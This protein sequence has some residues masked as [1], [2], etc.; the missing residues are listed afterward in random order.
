MA[1][2]SR[3]GLIG[4]ALLGGF[5]LLALLGAPETTFRVVEGTI[6][7]PVRFAVLLV[8]LYL[9]RPIL[10]LP[11]TIAAAIVGFGYGLQ[12]G[13]PVA[14]LGTTLSA[15]PPYYVGTALRSESGRLGRW[16]AAGESYFSVTGDTRGVIAVRLAPTPSDPV[17]Y[18]AGLSNVRVRPFILGTAIGELHWT[19]VAV[20]AGASARELTAGELAITSPL[21]VLG[22]AG[23]A[24][25]LLAGPLYRQLSERWVRT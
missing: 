12:L 1:W 25:I 21:L 20:A 23:L 8:L 2:T 15:I 14:L 13:I 4:L 6:E 5:I 10:A 19:V 22:A 24:T 18:A 9:F 16:C 17:S 11:T 7:D 3:H